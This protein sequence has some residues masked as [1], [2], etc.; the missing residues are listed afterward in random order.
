LW[1]GIEDNKIYDTE[2]YDEVNAPTEPV[3]LANKP[4]NKAVIER[5][6]KFLPPPITAPD[7]NAVQIGKGKKN[8][9][10]VDK[11]AQSKDEDTMFGG[12]NC[13]GHNHRS[14]CRKNQ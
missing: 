12:V 8:K 6:S 3:N 2:L 11:E 4:E 7:P 5:L 1:R 9:I 14:S 10:V 13:C